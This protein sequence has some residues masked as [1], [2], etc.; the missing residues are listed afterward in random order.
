MALIEPFMVKSEL[1]KS[2]GESFVLKADTGESL[3]VKDI[4]LMREN[5]NYV[6]ISIDRDTVGFFRTKGHTL[7]SHLY[8]P[9]GIRSA[10]YGALKSVRSKTLLSLMIRRGYFK[11]FP[12][13]EGQKFVITPYPE[14][15]SL[16]C[17][18]VIYEKYD[19][20]DIKKEDINGSE[21]KEYVYVAYGQ[22]SDTVKAA[23]EYVYDV[24]IN[25]EEFADFP[26]E[27]E[28][29]AK[30]EI[31][32]LGICG[33]EALSVADASNYTYTKY[34][35]LFKGRKMLFDTEKKG[36][37][38]YLWYY[39]GASGQVGGSGFSV[40]GQYTEKDYRLPLLFD[41]PIKFA[42]GEELRVIL[43]VGA[44]GSGS[45]FT[46]DFLELGLILRAKITE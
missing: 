15:K 7:S 30:T 19:A 31:E 21:A 32:L 13:A 11:G 4:F 28:C 42:S 29:P 3:L 38:V 20:G 45:A 17:V 12:V 23:G 9:S 41:T 22:I 46:N 6:T 35:K 33:W 44:A 34:L 5:C 1:E 24:M 26:F 8:P 40:M 14:D 10:T 37:P 27:R 25:P 16:G 18:C 36:L 2:A 43:E 39:S